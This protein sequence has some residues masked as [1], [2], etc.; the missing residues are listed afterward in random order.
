MY[1]IA[2]VPERVRER[3]TGLVSA[4]GLGEGI[5]TELGDSGPRRSG[6]RGASGGCSSTSR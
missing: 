6:E 4:S 3:S 2:H 5:E 1:E